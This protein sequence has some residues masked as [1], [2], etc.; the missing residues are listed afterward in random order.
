L[1]GAYGQVH[2]IVPTLLERA[3][4]ADDLFFDAVGQIEM[5]RWS[6]GRVVL[7]GDAA[8]CL[9]LLAGQGAAM[10]VAGATVLDTALA[11][12]AWDVETAITR[13]ERRLRPTMLQRQ[14]AGRRMALW[15]VPNSRL[16]ITVRDWTTR[17][18]LWPGIN[19]IARRAL[20]L[21]G[22]L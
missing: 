6:R 22:K 7:L 12:S 1:H 4:R 21:G 11:N 16:Q 2:W 15:F 19:Q 13:Y 10:A 3:D 17:I 8:W 5:P 18:L 14:A 9:S 20:G